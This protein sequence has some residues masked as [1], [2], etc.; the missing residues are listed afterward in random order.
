MLCTLKAGVSEIA[1]KQEIGRGLHLPVDI[2]GNRCLDRILNQLTVIAN[3]Y[4]EHFAVTIQNDFNDN[5]NTEI[6]KKEYSTEGVF[7]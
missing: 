3:D 6:K 4:Y 1:K 2:T 5:N 7:K